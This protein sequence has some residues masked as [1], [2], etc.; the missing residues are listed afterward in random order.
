[1]V[2]PS[3][4]ICHNCEV[5]LARVHQIECSDDLNAKNLWKFEI[6]P[7]NSITLNFC[8]FLWKNI[9]WCTLHLICCMYLTNKGHSW[10]FWQHWADILKSLIISCA[11]QKFRLVGRFVCQIKLWHTDPKPVDYYDEKMRSSLELKTVNQMYQ[12][13]WRL[14]VASRVNWQLVETLGLRR[15]S[16]LLWSNL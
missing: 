14:K 9:I 1:M 3:K 16:C 8:N 12:K 7:L 4:G 10:V 11:N 2:M 15:G 13:W 6:L 5:N